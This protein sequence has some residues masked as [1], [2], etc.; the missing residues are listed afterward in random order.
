MLQVKNRIASLLVAAAV[1][2]GGLSLS[3]SP[4]AA[5]EKGAI[6]AVNTR[7][8]AVDAK[9][10]EAKESAAVANGAAQSAQAA[11]QQANQKVDQLTAQLAVLEQRLSAT[12]AGGKTPRN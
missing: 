7:V 12:R 1:T 3:A 6:D 10:Y 9:A 8:T 11:A 2:A 5:D 4:C